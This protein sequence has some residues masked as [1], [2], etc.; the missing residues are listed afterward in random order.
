MKKVGN[1]AGKADMAKRTVRVNRD[2]VSGN[3]QV[4]VAPVKYVET[5]DLAKM[6]ASNT[7][8]TKKLLGEDK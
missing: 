3:T 7:K 1:Y 2:V 6:S 5:K 8:N 4:P